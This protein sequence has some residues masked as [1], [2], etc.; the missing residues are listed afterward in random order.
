MIDI[1]HTLRA[2]IQA[3]VIGAAAPITS[4]WMGARSVWRMSIMA[5][6]SLEIMGSTPMA[7]AA[8]GRARGERWSRRGRRPRIDVSPR[9][10]AGQSASRGASPRASDRRTRLSARKA[11]IGQSEAAT[12]IG[13]SSASALSTSRISDSR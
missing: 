3:L 8:D 6:S 10:R 9:A 5:S 2:P 7:F 13:Q 4:A 11:R 1:R 12:S